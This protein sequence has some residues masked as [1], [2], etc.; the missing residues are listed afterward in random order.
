M[1]FR[2][3]AEAAKPHLNR[4]VVVVNTPGAGGAIG[5]TQAAQKPGN[6]LNVNSYTSEIFTLP[7]FAPTHFSGKD[8]RPIILVNEDPACLVVPAESKLDTI[9]KFI[10]EAKANPG[11]VSIGNSGFGNI[12]HLSAAAFAKK[13]GLDLLQIP[14]TGAA[15]TVQAALSNQIAAFVASPPEVASQVQGGKLK[16]IAVMSDKRSASFPE[17]P[18]LKEKGI[19]LVIGTWRAVGAPASTPDELVKVL[20]DGFARG[21]KEKSF[22]DFMAQRGL[23]VRYLSTKDLVDFVNRERPF[24]ESLAAEVAKTR[25]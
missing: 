7:Q 18:T 19:D 17:V 23:T 25:Q 16:I 22:V 12:W 21:M 4:T 2:A 9:E 5:L 1:T 20:H 3:L 10:A 24:Y 14:Y 11:R 8:F 13:A 6:G 15:P